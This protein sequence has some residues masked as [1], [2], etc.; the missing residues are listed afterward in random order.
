MSSTI[1]TSRPSIGGVEVLEDPHDAA[2]VGRRAVRGHGHEVDLARDRDLAHEVGQEEH[3]A[4]EDADEQ[5]VAVRV[6]PR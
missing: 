3:R 6:L 5:Q 2:R 4:L 1:R